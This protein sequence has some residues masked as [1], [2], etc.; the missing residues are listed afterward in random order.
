M[1]AR[2]R[3]AV[4]RVW[5][6]LGKLLSM[7]SSS[8]PPKGGLVRTMSTRSDGPVADV[9]PRQRVV[10][11][12]EAR[13]LNAVQQHVGDAEHVRELLLL[14]GPQRLLHQLLVLN[15]LHVTL[16][17]VADGAGEKAAGAAGRVE[18]NLAGPGVDAIHHEGRDGARRVILARVAGALQVS[19]GSA[20]RCRR[21]AAAR[22]DC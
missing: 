3:S 17:H 8:F 18:E 6:C 22:R 4:S 5:K 13:I 15:L 10:V 20:R 21:S 2:K 7:P 11:A 16:A 12:H 14:D 9:G 19:Q 1:R